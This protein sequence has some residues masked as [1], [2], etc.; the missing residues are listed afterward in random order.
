MTATRQR[1]LNNATLLSHDLFAPHTNIGYANLE[2]EM[3]TFITR[4]GWTKLDTLLGLVRTAYTGL[5]LTPVA[6][7]GETAKISPNTSAAA[8]GVTFTALPALVD[9]IPD[10]TVTYQWKRDGSNIGGA[11]SQAYTTTVSDQNTSLK[12]TITY[13]NTGGNITQDTPSVSIT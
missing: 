11:T 13:T 8:Y 3:R 6:M 7:D 1:K 2:R 5:A 4:N 12:C 9:G 10:I